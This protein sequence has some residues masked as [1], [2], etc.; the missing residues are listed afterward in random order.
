MYKLTLGCTKLQTL[1]F[2]ILKYSPVIQ[3]LQLY[4]CNPVLKPYKNTY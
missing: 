3:T 1:N 2:Y 4:V